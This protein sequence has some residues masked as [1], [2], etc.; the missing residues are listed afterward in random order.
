MAAEVEEW[1]C[2]L[3]LDGMA[4]GQ[5]DRP[6]YMLSN[7]RYFTGWFITFQLS[8]ILTYFNWP[9]PSSL[10]L[11]AQIFPWWRHCGVS[12]YWVVPAAVLRSYL[13][14]LLLHCFLYPD[15]RSDPW[16]TWTAWYREHTACRTTW[17][18][19]GWVEQQGLKGVGRKQAKWWWHS[20]CSEW[21]ATCG[22][23]T[24][25]RGSGSPCSQET[26]LEATRWLDLERK[27]N[28][29]V[30]SSVASGQHSCR[31]WRRAPA[32]S[33]TSLTR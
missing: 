11:Q 15:S 31:A 4:P 9:G 12:T 25:R 8:K 27:C 13:I 16:Q 26:R 33:E 22:G 6:H 1:H 17:L 24:T 23:S 10:H 18:P 3:S 19:Q 21:Q 32:G 29:M 20:G 28:L 14:E 30:S 5:V 2:L 7:Y